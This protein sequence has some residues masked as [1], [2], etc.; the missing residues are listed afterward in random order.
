[1]DAACPHDRNEIGAKGCYAAVAPGEVE[2]GVHTSVGER[3]RSEKGVVVVVAEK[4][5]DNKVGVQIILRRA[6]RGAFSTKHESS[7]RAKIVE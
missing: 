4:A 7:E 5:G 1:M 6:K 3:R 2:D